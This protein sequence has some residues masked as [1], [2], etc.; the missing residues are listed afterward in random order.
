M[1]HESALQMEQAF[2]DLRMQILD[3]IEDVNK[4]RTFNGLSMNRVGLTQSI[5]EEIKNTGMQLDRLKIEAT[6]YGD[7][8][9][10]IVKDEQKAFDR[11]KSQF[12]QSVIK[13]EKNKHK[14]LKNDREM[15]LAGAVSPAELR[16]WRAR[17][18]DELVGTSNEIT[19]TL[20]ETVQIME[21]ELKK[22]HANISTLQESSRMLTESKKRHELLDDVMRVSRGLILK[23][24]RADWT[25]RML[26]LFAFLFFVGVV[27]NIIRRRVWIPGSSLLFR[28]FKYVF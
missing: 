5:H 25:D 7:R 8:F 21:G 24:E 12:R 22:S 26:M 16:K 14:Q 11:L 20:R 13:A 28:W 2:A 9:S 15:L 6:R 4:L 10:N 1:A 17:D 3:I 27:L 18:G 19:S 23:L